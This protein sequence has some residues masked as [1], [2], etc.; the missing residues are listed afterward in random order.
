MRRVRGRMWPLLCVLTVLLIALIILVALDHLVSAPKHISSTHIDVSVTTD[1]A[2]PLGRSQFAPGITHVDNSL[3]YLSGTNSLAAIQNASALLRKSVTYQN[4][5]IMGW[6]LPDPWPD[7]SASEPSNWSALDARL[8]LIANTGG[9]AV[10]TLCEAPWWMKGQLQPNGTT[11][12]LTQ[13]DEWSTRAYSSRILDDEMGAW[14]HL[15]QRVA[16]RYMAPPYNVRYFQV[17]N[18]L[19]GYYNPV[20]ND[21]DYTTSAGHPGTPSATHGYT[22]M[23]NLV[24]GRLM[25]VADSLGIARS[26][27]QVGGPYPVMDTWSSRTRAIL[28]P[29]RRRTERS[30]SVRST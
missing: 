8:Q 7:P 2:S 16:E 10:L 15:V 27:V 25:S 13:A 20:T 30:I 5:P 19:K 1:R 22:Y 14:L 6:G 17:W 12:A 18:E 28:R 4:T 11:L 3:D 9:V 24:Y 23:Y 26:D 21:Y 29:S